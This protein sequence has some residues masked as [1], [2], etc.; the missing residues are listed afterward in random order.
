MAIA[1]APAGGISEVVGGPCMLT[2]V[3]LDIIHSALRLSDNTTWGC[4]YNVSL[5]E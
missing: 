2:T 5:R 1:E 3:Q 4:E